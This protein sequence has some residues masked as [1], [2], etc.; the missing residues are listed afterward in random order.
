MGG[1]L[2]QAT[3]RIARNKVP[4]ELP[5]VQTSKRPPAGVEEELSGLGE[6]P[7]AAVAAVAAAAAAAAAAA[8]SAAV[9]AAVTSTSILLAACFGIAAQ[10]AL[11][12]T[13]AG[14]CR[15]QRGKNNTRVVN[16]EATYGTVP[17]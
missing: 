8:V 2:Q 3:L 9:S 5:L 15:V 4:E 10:Q 16:R 6:L 1:N 14:P 11:S 17:V 13:G 7:L 12:H